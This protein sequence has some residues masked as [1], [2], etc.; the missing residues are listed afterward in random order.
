MAE[1]YV[2][3][4]KDAFVIAVANW[5]L[6]TF[7]SIEALVVLDTIYRNGLRL[8]P[9][10]CREWGDEPHEPQEVCPSCGHFG[11]HHYAMDGCYGCTEPDANDDYQ[12]GSS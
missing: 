7:L 2:P 8:R 6:R 1:H 9:G 11:L 12:A 5:W 10:G 3:T 4:R